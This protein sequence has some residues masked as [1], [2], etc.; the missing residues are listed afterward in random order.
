[1]QRYDTFQ[2]VDS[3]VGRLEYE[4]RVLLHRLNVNRALP[5]R[6]DR[7]TA[8]LERLVPTLRFARRVRDRLAV[9]TAVR[10][11]PRPEPVEVRPGGRYLFE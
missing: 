9:P 7:R 5:A 8:R 1:M 10:V 6:Q 4:Q 2:A 11:A 3:L